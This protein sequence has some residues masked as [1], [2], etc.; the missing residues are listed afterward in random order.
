MAKRWQLLFALLVALLA[1][2]TLPPMTER[3]V[4]FGQ[5][6]LWMGMR[7]GDVYELQGRLKL[8]GL[9]TG[10]IH[11]HFDRRTYLAVRQFQYRWGLRVD[12]VVGPR[13]KLKLWQATKHWYPGLEK[14]AGKPTIPI[15]KM[16]SR[17]PRV[18]EMQAR[19]KFLGYDPGPIDGRYGW[20]TLRAVRTFQARFGLP[21]DGIAGCAPGQ[22]VGGHQ[23]LAVGN[24]GPRRAAAACSSAPG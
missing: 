5:Q 13:T 9:Y 12:G 24:G 23:A 10:P 14:R 6:T 2:T 20:R 18:R 1:S 11:G 4:A 21:V 17:G 16:G 3:A 15:L 19:L 22:T 8:L 7:G